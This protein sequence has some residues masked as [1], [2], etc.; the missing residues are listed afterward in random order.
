[1]K[2]EGKISDVTLVSKTL[3]RTETNE[4]KLVGLH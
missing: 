3:C 2:R 4:Q 1:M